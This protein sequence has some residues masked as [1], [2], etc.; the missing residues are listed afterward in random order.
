MLKS[1]NREGD[2]L[3]DHKV[4]QARNDGAKTNLVEDEKERSR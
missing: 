2:P 3:E 4:I 1:S